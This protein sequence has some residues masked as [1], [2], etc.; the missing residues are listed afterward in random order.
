MPVPS[1]TEARRP[2]LAAPQVESVTMDPASFDLR[3]LSAEQ[4]AALYDAARRRAEQLRRA[5]LREFATAVLR[6]LR[7]ELPQR[8]A[9][10]PR[11]RQQ[12]I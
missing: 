10:A 9:R 7:A 2:R 6:W 12:F 4:H 1:P 5:A 11:R 3:S 8:N